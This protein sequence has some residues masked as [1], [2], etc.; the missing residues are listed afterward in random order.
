MSDNNDTEMFAFGENSFEG[1]DCPAVKAGVDPSLND[2]VREVTS[3]YDSYM[4]DLEGKHVGVTE[5][6]N[7][8]EAWF[9]I[10]EEARIGSAIYREAEYIAEELGWLDDVPKTVRVAWADEVE[11]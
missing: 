2:V 10:M 5:E 11:K 3:A 9:A 1:C 6:E 7:A 4:M 8:K